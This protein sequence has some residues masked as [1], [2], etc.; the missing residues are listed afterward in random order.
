M[1][2]FQ[3]VT[4]SQGS[5]HQQLHE[6]ESNS[7]DQSQQRSDGE[8]CVWHKACQEEIAFLLECDL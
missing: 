5:L 6:D 8:L 3:I 1:G 7:D 4:S 2:L